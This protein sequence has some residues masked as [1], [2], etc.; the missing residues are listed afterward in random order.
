MNYPYV[1]LV[2]CIRL[3]LIPLIFNFLKTCEDLT[4]YDELDHDIHI[5]YGKDASMDDLIPWRCSKCAHN[6]LIEDHGP[7]VEF[8]LY[9]CVGIDPILSHV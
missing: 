7:L 1:L 2:F 3:R 9:S 5:G 4:L 8:S 6:E